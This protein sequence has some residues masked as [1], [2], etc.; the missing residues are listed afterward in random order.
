LEIAWAEAAFNLLL[1]M[2]ASH[3]SYNLSL[4]YEE[5]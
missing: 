3:V 1:F 2:L 5:I 4:F